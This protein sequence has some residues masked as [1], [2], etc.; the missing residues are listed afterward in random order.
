M[1]AVPATVSTMFRL[2]RI[3]FLL[4]VL[5]F[6]GVGTVISAYESTD[7]DHPLLVHVYA[8]K[9]DRSVAVENYVSTLRHD[10]F[11]SV[12]AFIGKEALRHGVALDSPIR[13]F[14]DPEPLDTIP[15][16]APNARYWQILAWSLRM[17]W[18]AFRLA[19]QSTQRS[20]DITLFAVYHDSGTTLALDGSTA[21]RRGLIAVAHLFADRQRAGSNDVVVAHELLHT[22]GASDKYA[23]DTNLPIY[24]QGYAEPAAK[25]RYPQQLT[26]VMAGRRPISPA[27]AAMPSELEAVVVGPLTAE[28][29]GW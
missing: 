27:E 25:P 4:Y 3:T 19:W 29:I 7:W 20:P 11:E 16:L 1:L 8:V 10:R 2:L 12:A 26:E 18:L 6:V 5:A 9:G 17:R 22:L 24:P 14:I 13:F 21:L 15:T 23:L 28:E